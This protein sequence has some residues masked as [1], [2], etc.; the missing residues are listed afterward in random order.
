MY[1]AKILKTEN[2]GPIKVGD[3]IGW[4]VNEKEEL[5]GFTIPED[6]KEEKKEK[7]EKKITK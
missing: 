2:D 4:A 7:K 1:I 5:D 3:V 6:A